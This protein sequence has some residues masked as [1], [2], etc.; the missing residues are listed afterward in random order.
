MADAPQVPAAETLRQYLAERDVA[1]ASCGYNLRG[2]QGVLCPE[3]GTVIPSP[4]AEYLKRQRMDAAALQL[5]CEKCGY[6]V[7]GFDAVRCPECGREELERFTGKPPRRR[8]RWLAQ[9]WMVLG[10]GLGVT[11][12]IACAT[13]GV[14]QHLGGPAGSVDPWIGALVSLVPVALSAAWWWWR[15]T[16]ERL[17]PGE[18]RAIGAVCVVIGFVAIVVAMRAIR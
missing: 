11:M 7:T 2:A 18:R 17:E 12:S 13:I 16:I 15:R 5:M 9:A 8:R 3:C 1:C 6:V 10:T 4:P 14:V